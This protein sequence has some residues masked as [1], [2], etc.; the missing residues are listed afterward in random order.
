MHTYIGVVPG[1]GSGEGP[2]APNGVPRGEHG[3]VQWTTVG[4][5]AERERPIFLAYKSISCSSLLQCSRRRKADSVAN[6]L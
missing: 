1:Q 2:Q 5:G 4:F 6:S 3:G